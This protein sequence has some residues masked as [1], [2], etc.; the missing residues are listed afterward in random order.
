MFMKDKVIT[1]SNDIINLYT[2]DKR[3]KII[4]KKNVKDAVNLENEISSENLY[5]LLEGE[6]IYIKQ[7]LLPNTNNENINSIIMNKLN[8]IYGKK[9]EDIYYTY[10][11]WRSNIK[12]IQIMLYCI[13]CDKLKITKQK[14]YKL[15]IKK[16][17]LI[18]L[19]Y[20]RY[21]KKSITEKDY[22]VILK[23][24][25]SI[26]ILAYSDRKLL[27]NQIINEETIES[28]LQF[29]INKMR[30]YKCSI[31]K[32]YSININQTIMQKFLQ[33]ED[34]PDIIN[35][36]VINLGNITEEEII[37]YYIENRRK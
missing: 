13:S 21:Y 25:S 30:T 20:I 5:I 16:V 17:N 23:H 12:E 11:K 37:D 27:S 33:R 8:Y 15:Q 6:E 4:D 31:N 26:Y 1:I 7:L 10:S 29:L 18:Q 3:N 24:N 35:Y 9:A 34:K 19:N 2:I 36:K 28:S 22:I 14:N 32:I